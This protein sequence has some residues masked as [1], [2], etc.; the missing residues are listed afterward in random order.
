PIIWGIL[1]I[2]LVIAGLAWWQ[3][4]S[5]EDDLTD[6]VL[7]SWA[8][9]QTSQ[10]SN[11][12]EL[13]INQLS[14]RSLDWISVQQILLAQNKLTRRGELI[15]SLKF[16]SSESEAPPEI[17]FSPDLTE[18]IL[19]HEIIYVDRRGRLIALEQDE[20]FRLGSDRWLLSPAD[21]SYW[22]E[23]PLEENIQYSQN[24]RFA[25]AAPDRDAEFVAQIVSGLEARLDETCETGFQRACWQLNQPQILLQF[26]P[27]ITD[28]LLLGEYQID[29]QT[30]VLPSP[31]LIGNPVDSSQELLLIQAYADVF[32][33]DYL[34]L[35]F[36]LDEGFASTPFLRAVTNSALGQS[37][38]VSPLT[39]SDFKRIEEELD[40]I[41][42]AFNQNRVLGEG[43]NGFQQFMDIPVRTTFRIMMQFRMQ[44]PK[45]TPQVLLDEYASSSN[46]PFFPEILLNQDDWPAFVQYVQTRA[47]L[48]D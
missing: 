31:S 39:V 48:E 45:I 11:D 12:P 32:L 1:G 3:I 5:T 40:E 10:L 42:I 18:A 6:A 47:A 4:E 28:Q 21:V 46:Q 33:E 7:E 24:Q 37:D 19:T 25:F 26:S 38:A 44:S 27:T 41:E 14:G 15:S 43:T 23:S 36:S 9:V 34:L 35:L 2:L 8:I 22:G 30:F 13:L 17:A 29:A 20:V 16:E